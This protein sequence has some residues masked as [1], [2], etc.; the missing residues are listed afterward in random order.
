M[1]DTLPTFGDHHKRLS[2]QG[3]SLCPISVL[4]LTYP[5]TV[6]WGA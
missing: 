5:L 3:T 6:V 2:R 4:M 1:D